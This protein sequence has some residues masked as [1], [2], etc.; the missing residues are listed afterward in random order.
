M[1]PGFRDIA[2]GGGKNSLGD[3]LKSLGEV[4]SGYFVRYRLALYLLSVV[5]VVNSIVLEVD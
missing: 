1:A 4:L 5:P 3:T 2:L